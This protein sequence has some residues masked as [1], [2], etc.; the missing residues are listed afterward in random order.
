[1]YPAVLLKYFISTAVILLASLALKVQVTLPYNK[2]NTLQHIILA[3]RYVIESLF[4]FSA[5]ESKH[6]HSHSEKKLRIYVGN[7]IRKL[8]IQVTTHVFKL[9]AGNCHR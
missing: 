1:M 3:V 6:K 2:E 8:Q 4:P 7:S 9:S 5:T